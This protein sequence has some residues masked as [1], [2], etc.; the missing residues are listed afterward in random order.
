MI[1]IVGLGA[2]DITQISFSAVEKLKSNLPIY[3]RTEKHPVVEKLDIEYKS[4][5]SYYEEYENFEQVYSKIANE[6][7]NLG[8]KE[9]LIYAVPGHPRV[10]EST[11]PLIE[12]IALKK[13]IEVEIIASMSFIDAMYNYLAFDPSEGFRLLDA[14]NI[15]KRDL[16][17]EANIIITQVYDRFIASNTKIKLMEYYNDEQE[18]YI[19]KSAGI[20]DLEYKKKIKLCDLDRVENEFDHLTSLFIAKSGKKRFR[21][22]EDLEEL[23]FDGKEGESKSYEELANQMKDTVLRLSS[24]IQE[25]DIDSMIEK[26]GSIVLQVIEFSKAGLEEGYFDFDEICDAAFDIKKM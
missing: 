21:S 11:V 13:G 8:E 10:A 20:K 25:D 23:V 18:M 2:G 17:C 4:F 26:L 6:I 16:D 9:D 14:F 5:D 24:S 15:R 19:V 7:V 12:E 1:T 3:L 22:I